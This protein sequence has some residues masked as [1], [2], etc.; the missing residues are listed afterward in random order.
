MILPTTEQSESVKTDASSTSKTLNKSVASL[1]DGNSDATAAHRV[2]ESDLSPEAKESLDILR[3]NFKSQNSEENVGRIPDA[4]ADAEIDA[5]YNKA[6]LKHK[7]SS[8]ITPPPMDDD[9]D[10][11]NNDDT[12]QDTHTLN[13]KD[14]SDMNAMLTRLQAFMDSESGL[15]GV[16]FAATQRTKAATQRTNAATQQNKATRLQNKSDSQDI[17]SK[18]TNNASKSILGD[19]RVDDDDDEN[20]VEDEEGEID[21]ENMTDEQIDK[22]FQASLKKRASTSENRL[23]P[24]SAAQSHGVRGGMRGIDDIPADIRGDADL[25]QLWLLVS[26]FGVPNNGDNGDNGVENSWQSPLD[27]EDDDT[28]CPAD[29]ISCEP[30]RNPTSSTLPPSNGTSKLA[31]RILRQSAPA[32]TST[33]TNEAMFDVDRDAEECLPDNFDKVIGLTLDKSLRKGNVQKTEKAAYIRTKYTL[34]SDDDNDDDNNDN[35][36]MDDDSDDEEVDYADMFG[37][38][39]GKKRVGKEEHPNAK[40]FREKIGDLGKM[41]NSEGNA[42]ARDLAL[43]A[44]QEHLDGKIALGKAKNVPSKLA[45]S[46]ENIGSN[47]PAKRS[48][49]IAM[50]IAD[51]N[52]HDND[53]DDEMSVE[54]KTNV[55]NID[56][57]EMDHV[58]ET[59]AFIRELATLPA[60]PLRLKDLTFGIPDLSDTNAGNNNVTE[61]TETTKP[62]KK[63]NAVSSERILPGR[64][65]PGGVVQ[66]LSTAGP[67]VNPV[68]VN[69]NNGGQDQQR[70]KKRSVSVFDADYTDVNSADATTL[71]NEAD[72]EVTLADYMKLMDM[73]LYRTMKNPAEGKTKGKKSQGKSGKKRNQPSILTDADDEWDRN[74]DL[75]YDDMFLD[76]DSD[77]DF[78]GNLDDEDDNLYN[79]LDGRGV[80]EAQILKR[81]LSAYEEE[82]GEIGPLRTMFSVLGINIPENMDSENRKMKAKKSADK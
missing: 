76:G 4:Q 25:E 49:R 41:A 27:D 69:L 54:I 15:D 18:T 42:S 59:E 8:K 63:V 22:L 44:L 71:T 52:D 32:A 28:A 13:I 62:R 46:H 38:S 64:C 14:S 11:D 65:V 12:T 2:K 39:D 30:A 56:D 43:Q 48:S 1:I 58:V 68:D 73:E 66:N 60:K 29:A 10:A 19:V 23:Q 3:K 72:D 33:H 37:Y 51:D 34:D 45:P 47:A 81:L 17:M 16:E 21:M 40:L 74:P 61:D 79:S 9:N 6:L 77:N 78:A 67:N 50:K 20:T 70:P 57:V 55:C 82:E 80:N 36:A 53:D 31:Q 7:T 24:S 26:K 5:A 35:T 75:D